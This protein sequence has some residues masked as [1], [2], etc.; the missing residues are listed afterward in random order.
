MGF[1]I[2]ISHFITIMLI[3]DLSEYKYWQLIHTYSFYAT[4]ILVS[5][6]DKS[7]S[8]QMVFNFFG[9]NILNII[10]KYYFLDTWYNGW[11]KNANINT[12]WKQL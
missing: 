3:F 2:K 6:T 9:F 5:R 8:S 1:N 7:A 4:P 12:K 11:L 10:N